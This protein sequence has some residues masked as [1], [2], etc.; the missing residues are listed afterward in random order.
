MV[1]CYAIGVRFTISYDIHSPSIYKYVIA[2]ILCSFLV[3]Q[4]P[5]IVP[6]LEEDIGCTEIIFLNKISQDSTLFVLSFRYWCVVG[7]FS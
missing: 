1:T 5:N 2:F 4:F 6:F 3:E 7:L